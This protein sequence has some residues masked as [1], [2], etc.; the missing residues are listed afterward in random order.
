MSQIVRRVSIAANMMASPEK[1]RTTFGAR[2]V[3]AILMTGGFL[4]C[5]AM[6]VCMSVAVVAMVDSN[7]SL[8]F[9]WNEQTQNLVLSSFF[10]GYVVTQVPGGMMT[11][12]WGAQRLL[13]ISVGLCALATLLIP[14]AAAYGDYVLVCTCRVFCGLCQGV[15][16]PV[17]H[18]LLAK[19]VPHLERGRFTSFVYSG[20]WI[21]NVIALQSSGI[22][23][24]SA[25]GWPSCFYFWGV[26]SLVW[27]IAWY[28]LGKESPA[29]HPGIA[30]DEKIFIESSLGIVETTETISTPWKSILT[31]VP[32]W[33]LLIAQCTQ[34]WG[35]WMLLSKIPSYMHKV[36]NYDIQRNGLMS[37]LP[38][39]S[40]WLLSFP[41]SFGSDWA[42][43]SNKVSMRTSRMICNTVGEILPALALIGLGFVNNQ[44]QLLAVSILVIAVS[45]NIAVYCGHHANHMDLSPNFAGPLMGFTNAAANVC[46]IFA[47]LVQGFIVKDPTNV[48]QWRTI[49]L[50]TS[51][52][53]IIGALAFLLFGSVKVQNWNNPTSKTNGKLY[54]LPE[55]SAI[56]VLNKTINS[57]EKIER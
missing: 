5:Y 11:Q 34:A 19:W 38:Y 30:S 18:T 3:Q 56:S 45:G 21:G 40:A 2:H 16:P 23:A 33:A 54:N 48:S 12:R 20:G 51:G 39:L 46:S 25:I 14:L 27:S 37:S 1:P 55:V 9:D 49:F 36:L 35:F 24:G 6:R 47:P 8:R 7:K 22:L 10:W 28:F 42:I 57:D 41:M 53:Y 29:E 52:M 31:S 13:G 50:L 43:H 4:C 26:V 32:V 44:Q 15:V 17:L